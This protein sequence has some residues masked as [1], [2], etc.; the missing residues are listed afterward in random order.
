MK[1][2]GVIVNTQ[3]IGVLVKM[4]ICG[5]LVHVIANPTKYVK[6]MNIQIL[7]IVYA[8]N[9]FGKLVLE[10]DSVILNTTEV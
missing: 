10:C 4:I 5:I 7:K 1:N 6:V 8:R 3:K 2:V 9:I